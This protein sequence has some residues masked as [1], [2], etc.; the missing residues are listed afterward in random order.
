MITITNAQAKK[1]MAL[2]PRNEEIEYVDMNQYKILL[3][4]NANLGTW[5]LQTCVAI[6]IC[7]NDGAIRYLAHVNIFENGVDKKDFYFVRE[8]LKELEQKIYKFDETKVKIDIISSYS[9]I[10][11][12]QSLNERL[13]LQIIDQ[14]SANYGHIKPDLHNGWTVLM[15]PTGTTKVLTFI[16][17][18]LLKSNEQQK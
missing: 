12:L 5:N 8:S 3:N 6:A 11:K 7:I 15:T 17:E 10:N 13:L 18:N 9:Y 4:S 1:I 2:V 14:F 16:E